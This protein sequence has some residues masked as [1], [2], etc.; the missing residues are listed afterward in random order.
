MIF[1]TLKLQKISLFTKFIT[2][3]NSSNSRYLEENYYLIDYKLHEPLLQ[4]YT[5]TKYAKDNSLARE[6]YNYISTTKKKKILKEFGFDIP[7]DKNK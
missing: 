5:I 6:F 4:G 2:T 1:S 3:Y 7:I